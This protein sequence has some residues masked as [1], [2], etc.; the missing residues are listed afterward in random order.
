MP[1]V[2]AATAA[3]NLLKTSHYLGR[4]RQRVGM[5]KT[6]AASPLRPPQTHW[7][8]TLSGQAVWWWRGY[9]CVCNKLG[10]GVGPSE[11]VGCICIYHQP[12]IG[13]YRLN[14]IHDV[15][16]YHVLVGKVKEGPVFH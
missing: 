10:K 5:H 11:Y 4:G 2:S 1:L 8:S 13:T 3:R 12:L 15:H 14:D 6:R 16:S 9:V 7:I